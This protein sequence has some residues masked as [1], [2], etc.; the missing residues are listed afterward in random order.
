MI[1]QYFNQTRPLEVVD[2][3]ANKWGTIVV[4]FFVNDPNSKHCAVGLGSGFVVERHRMTFLVTARHVISDLTDGRPLIANI[5][6]TAVPLNGVPFVAPEEDDLAVAFLDPD[7]AKKQNL[8][9]VFPLRL[10]AREPQWQSSGVYVLLGYPGARN[11]LNLN[12]N[13]TTRKLVA[14]SSSQRIE[15]PRSSTHFRN[16]VAFAFDKKEAVNTDGMPI[17]VGLFK[18][19][20]GGPVLEVFVRREP[21]GTSTLSVSL[22]GV[23]IGWD[24]EHRE[25]LCCRSEVVSRLIDELAYHVDPVGH[26]AG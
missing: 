19:N 25:L 12:M 3:V 8:E 17:N 21:D 4:P 16:P 18:G 6:G 24:K 10:A 13:E 22:A 14:H 5:A 20:S 9:R 15:S 11:R 2:N 1:L 7:W 26:Y 23:F